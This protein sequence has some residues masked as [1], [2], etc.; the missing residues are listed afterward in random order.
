MRRR[1]NVRWVIALAVVALGTTVAFVSLQSGASA[2]DIDCRLPSRVDTTCRV[3]VGGHYQASVRTPLVTICQIN[4]LI[5]IKKETAGTDKVVAFGTTN[6]DGVF[7]KKVR[8]IK[9]STGQYYSQ[10][11]TFTPTGQSYSY[12]GATRCVGGKS[13]VRTLNN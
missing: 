6:V 5:K 11:Y 1:R 8:P 3:K 4:R 7:K 10:V 2:V 13:A 12:S 9:S